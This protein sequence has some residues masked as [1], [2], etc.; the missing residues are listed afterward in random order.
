M[1]GDCITQC[2]AWDEKG[3][4]FVTSDS[5]CRIVLWRV[6]GS[7]L[8]ATNILEDS[9]VEARSV[10]IIGDKVLYTAEDEFIYM[11]ELSAVEVSGGGV[12]KME[13]EHAN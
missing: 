12:P 10:V 13:C 9:E 11:W 5:S 2:I 4:R 1:L 6:D 3:S 7:T 8:R